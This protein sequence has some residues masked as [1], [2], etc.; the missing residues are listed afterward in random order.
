MTLDILSVEGRRLFG[1]RC[2]FPGVFEIGEGRR[3]WGG[4]FE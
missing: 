1:Q 2:Q 4:L 3:L